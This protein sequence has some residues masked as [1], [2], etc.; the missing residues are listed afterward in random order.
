KS[1]ASRVRRAGLGWLV[2]A[3]AVLGAL[4]PALLH[5][6]PS[7]P[8]SQITRFSIPLPKGTNTGRESAPVIAL[9][10]DGHRLVFSAEDAAGKRQLWL[11]P[12]DSFAAQPLTGTEG[13]AYSFWSP[14]GRSIAFFADNKLKKLDLGSGVI[15]TICQT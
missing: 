10:P 9:S 6:R 8:P 3:G 13:A 7:S 4:L 12:L 14:D 15:E 2:A 5:F 1:G 11:R